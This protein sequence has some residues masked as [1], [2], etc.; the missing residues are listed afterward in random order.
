MF[1]ESQ[2]YVVYI[3][4]RGADGIDL[5]EHHN[6]D[7]V[8]LDFYMPEMNGGEVARVLK[9]LRPDIPIILLSAYATEPENGWD[10][11]DAF[12]MKGE[13]PRVLLNTLDHLLHRAA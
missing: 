2:G 9:H 12:V 4:A 11:V 10:D 13:N 1:L 8:V 3:A 7:A 6:V 5:L